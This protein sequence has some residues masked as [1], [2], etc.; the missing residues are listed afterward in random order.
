[1]GENTTQPH[2]IPPAE[3]SSPSFPSRGEAIGEVEGEEGEVEGG[4]EE[5]E[6]GRTEGI[7]RGERVGNEERVGVVGGELIGGGLRVP[8][9]GI[10]SPSI[11][12]SSS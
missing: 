2:N 8:G 4:G 6:V 7:W 10:P 3:S 9:G 12:S 1:M 5:G 11:P